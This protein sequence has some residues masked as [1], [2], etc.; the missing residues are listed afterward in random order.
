MAS[1]LN[2]DLPIDDSK[3]WWLENDSRLFLQI[4]NSINGKVLTL[5]NHC[6]FVK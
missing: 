6:E 2:E 5:I 1:H 4:H 3:D